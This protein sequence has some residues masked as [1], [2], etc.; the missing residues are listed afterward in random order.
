MD[1]FVGRTN[2]FMPSHMSVQTHATVRNQQAELLIGYILEIFAEKLHRDGYIANPAPPIAQVLFEKDD[3]RDIFDHYI[4]LNIVKPIAKIK[5]SLQ[6]WVQL[7]CY[8]GNKT[9]KPE[10][11]KTYEIRETLI[12]G[13]GLRRWLREENVTFRTIHFTVGSAKYTYDWF[14]TAKDCAYD[15]SL[16]P[17][18][19]IESNRLFAELDQLATNARTEQLFFKKLEQVRSDVNSQIGIFINTMFHHLYKWFLAGLP[20][21][22][23]AD[24]QADLLNHLRQTR[25]KLVIATLEA[26]KQG[27]ENIKGT[28]GRIMLGEETSDPIMLRTLK[29]L[30]QTKPFLSVALEAEANWEKWIQQHQKAPNGYNSLEDYIRELWNSSDDVHL[31]NRRLL[32]RIH[33]DSAVNYVQDIDILGVT[34]HNLYQGKHKQNLVEAISKKIASNCINSNIQEPI[35]LYKRLISNYALQILKNSR[36]FESINGTNIK[37]SFLYLEE[38]LSNYYQ[39]L[40]FRSVN[41]PLPIS[42]CRH[43]S[44]AN[45]NAYE[46]MKVVCSRVNN[47]PLAII[48]GKFFRR[49]EFARRV[50]EESYVGLTTKFEYQGSKFLERYPGLPMIMFV[51]MDTNLSPPEYAIRKL[52]TSGWDVFFS[53]QKLKDFL[54]ELSH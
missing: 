34:E 30:L 42:Y 21:S 31:I 23:L 7:T 35:D 11:N 48:K 24:K 12:E 47:Y 29:R 46:N 37:P 38:A 54:D 16:Y 9:G 8:K 27:G 50:K 6:L 20:S 44:S 26:A 2:H 13:L 17:D 14:K 51:D 39:L 45:I 32:L 43:F 25:Q 22:E 4:E 36:K 28:A 3:C 49:Q 41:L 5:G 1:I 53:I 19:S 33:T 15:L 52:V 40:N 10:P 18:D